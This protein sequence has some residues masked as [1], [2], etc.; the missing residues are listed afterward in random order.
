V[1][2]VS[3]YNPFWFLQLGES[4]SKHMLS[5]IVYC[6]HIQFYL[7][8]YGQMSYA[9]SVGNNWAHIVS[10]YISISVLWSGEMC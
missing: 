6:K 3:T 2:V 5:L 1:S 10:S 7:H 4:Y 8:S 9:E